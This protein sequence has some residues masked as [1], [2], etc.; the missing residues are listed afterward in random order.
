MA[1][2]FNSLARVTAVLFVA[3]GLF[4][5]AVAAPAAGGDAAKILSLSGQVSLERESDEWALQ[6]GDAVLPGQVIRTGSDGQAVLQLEDGSKFEVFPGS[7]VVFRANRGNLRD[8]LDILLGKVKVQIE[9]FGGRPNPYR[10]NSAT[11]LI[12]VRGTSFVVKVDP[13][14]VTFI[15]V[16]E[17]LVSVTHRLIPSANEVL[18]RDGEALTVYPGE[19]LYPSSV[20][21]GRIAVRVIGTAVEH[22]LRA[23]RL[24]SGRGKSPVPGGAGVPAPGGDAGQAPPPPSDVPDGDS[25][26]GAGSSPPPGSPFQKRTRE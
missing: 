14:D 6:A 19:A 8:L 22:A 2:R 20:D 16:E 11:A 10:V 21:R 5:G 15:H 13:D 25:G 23:I 12:A 9:K 4:G 18:L 17:G 24:G 7:R 26:P 1:K 3:A